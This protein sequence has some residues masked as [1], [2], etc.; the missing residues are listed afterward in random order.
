M[1]DKINI[2]HN[3]EGVLGK[4]HSHRTDWGNLDS[5]KWCITLRAYVNEL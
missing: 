1:L 4:S 5:G 3:D 2:A